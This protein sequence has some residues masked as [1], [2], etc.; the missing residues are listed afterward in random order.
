V[1]ITA[2]RTFLVQLH[3]NVPV[4]PITCTTTRGSGFIFE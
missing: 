2:E 1:N 4:E 3:M